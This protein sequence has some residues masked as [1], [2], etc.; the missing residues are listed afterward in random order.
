LST[1]L[2]DAQPA[3]SD[4]SIQTD[5][6]LLNGV[7]A[8]AARVEGWVSEHGLR[9]T[10]SEAYSDLVRRALGE[11]KETA[12][13]GV[14]TLGEFMERRFEPAMRTCRWT[15]RRLREL[16]DRISRT[17]QILRTRIEFVNE[18]QTQALLSSMDRRAKLQLKLQQTVEGLSLVVLSYYAVG[19]IGYLVKGLKSA[20]LHVDAELVTGLAVPV[21]AGLLYWGI[22]RARR[23]A[24]G[25]ESPTPD[26]P[27]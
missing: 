10:A 25:Y 5:G 11:L 7:S 23:R 6:Q 9:F 18:R 14:Q 13:P 19:L 22:R 4:Q 21:V 1:R 26:K 16:S 2:T 20:G 27:Q 8:L 17:T 3:D 15:E 12:L 24:P